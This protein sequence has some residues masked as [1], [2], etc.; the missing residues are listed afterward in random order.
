MNRT[1]LLAIRLSVGHYDRIEVKCKQAYE[2]TESVHVAVVASVNRAD[3]KSKFVARMTR[4][5]RWR[6]HADSIADHIC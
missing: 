4:L 1:Y 2:P 5:T 3:S 6:D